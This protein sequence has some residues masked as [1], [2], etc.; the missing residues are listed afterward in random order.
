[1]QRQGTLSIAAALK[2]CYVAPQNPL[3]PIKNAAK[4]IHLPSGDSFFSKNSIC[5]RNYPRAY[6]GEDILGKAVTP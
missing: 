2:D 4:K 1:M 6:R 3:R 5:L